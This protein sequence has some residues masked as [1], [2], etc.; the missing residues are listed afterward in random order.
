M[1]PTHPAPPRHWG[2]GVQH[3]TPPAFLEHRRCGIWNPPGGHAVDAP[4]TRTR[5]VGSLARW[6]GGALTARHWT[7]ALGGI[8]RPRGIRRQSSALDWAQ[9]C[10]AAGSPPGA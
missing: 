6:C 3:G 7:P 4:Q 9:L 5:A 8:T 1:K 10:A 2:A